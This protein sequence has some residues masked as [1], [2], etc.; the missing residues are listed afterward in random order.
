MRLL[1]NLLVALWLLA[2]PVLAEDAAPPAWNGIAFSQAPEAGL[3]VCFDTD[4]A[5]AL[6]C[7][8]AACMAESGLGVEDCGQDFWCK[9]HGFAADIFVQHTEGPHWHAFVCGAADRQELDALV[10]VRCDADYYIECEAVRVW[11]DEGEE[12]LGATN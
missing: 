9:P 1:L 8:Q 11:S 5:A 10:A 7:A 12:L 4:A 3:G 6:S 2:V